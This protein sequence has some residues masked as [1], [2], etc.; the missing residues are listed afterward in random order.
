MATGPSNWINVTSTSASYPSN[1]LGGTTLSPTS[2]VLVGHSTA[3]DGFLLLSAD[4]GATSIQ[5]LSHD[6]TTN[7]LTLTIAASQACPVFIPIGG[8]DGMRWNNGIS[9]KTSNTNTT[10]VLY[11]RGLY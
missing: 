5:I 9:V 8:P 11:F 2:S 7:I 4:T 10:G 1:G 3:I 6:G